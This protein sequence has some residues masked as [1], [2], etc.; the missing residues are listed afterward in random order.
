MSISYFTQRGA[1]DSALG[2]LI[3]SF[4]LD[5][6][7]GRIDRHPA[8]VGCSLFRYTNSDLKNRTNQRPKRKTCTRE[9]NQLIL[10]CYF[11]S[12][13]TLIGYRKR[14]MEIKQ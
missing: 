4:F 8:N 7:H 6:Q 5:N 13:P 3:G 2:I 12:N 14:M 9:E 1:Q 10:Y 11:R